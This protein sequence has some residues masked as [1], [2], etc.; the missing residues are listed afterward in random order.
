MRR[1]RVTGVHAQSEHMPCRVHHAVLMAEV[2]HHYFPKLVEL[3]NY[4]CGQHCWENR[5]QAV[6][7]PGREPNVSLRH[8]M[9]RLG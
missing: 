2:V 5:D 3:H 1:D 9:F 8:G 7:V 6:T 4:R